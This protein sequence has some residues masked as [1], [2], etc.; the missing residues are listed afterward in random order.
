MQH[1]RPVRAALF[2]LLSLLLWTPVAAQEP[3]WS[4]TPRPSRAV[5]RDLPPQPPMPSMPVPHF[6]ESNIL[7]DRIEL[8]TLP[9]ENLVR[10]NIRPRDL[11]KQAFLLDTIVMNTIRPRPII[12]TP[13]APPRLPHETLPPKPRVYQGSM[14]FLPPLP[15]PT[16]V[17]KDHPQFEDPMPRPDHRRILGW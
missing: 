17:H 14:I 13:L 8:G 3:L 11:T 15:L 2:V 16:T 9:K 6:H 10:E 1:T 7:P 5:Q 12:Q 4:S